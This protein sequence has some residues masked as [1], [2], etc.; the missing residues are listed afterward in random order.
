MT[1]RDGRRVMLTGATGYVGGRLLHLLEE[2][3]ATVTCLARQPDALRARCA[4]GTQVVRGD[5]ITGAGLDEALAGADVAY[6]MVHSM[7]AHGDFRAADRAS[8]RNFGEAARRQGVRRI[9]YLG[10]LGSGEY[11]SPHLESRHEVGRILRESGVPTIELRASAIIGSGSL[12]FEMVRALVDRLPVMVWPKWVDTPTQ[13]IGIEDVLAY[14]MEAP[15]VDLPESAVVGIGGSDCVSYGELLMAYAREIGV[16]RFFIRVPVLTPRLSSL[17]LGLVTP[18]YARVG[19]ELVEGLKAPTVVEDDRALR[20]FSIQPMG[21]PEQMARALLNEDKEFAETRWSDATSSRGQQE[22]VW[23]GARRGSRMVDARSVFVPVAPSQAFAPIR[24]IGGNQ[25]WYHATW[26]WNVRGFIDLPFGG[27]G[28]RRG[29]RDPE[30]L[31][32]GD[33]LD[34]WRVEAIAPDHLLRLHAEMAL[35]GRAWLQFEVHEVPDGSVIH[36]TA[37]YDPRGVLG[38][39]YWYAMWPF[40]TF[41]F[42]GMLKNIAKAAHAR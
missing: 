6:F 24:R 42:G 37:L 40:H 4:P 7:G 9:V 20:M 2:S 32:A 25:G 21:V 36:Q 26:L 14:L 11:M 19:R 10:A 5:L 17:W 3:G 30:H 39:A 28:T 31:V 41:V 34:F 23:G 38:R 22:M 16:R 8:A 1:D 27:A 15:D 33:T 13:P 35:P 29:R 12:S 18:V